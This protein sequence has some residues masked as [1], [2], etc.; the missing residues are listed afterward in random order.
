M[1]DEGSLILVSNDWTNIRKKR[2][3]ADD[4]FSLKKWSEALDEY[5]ELV[6][7]SLNAN[8]PEDLCYFYY[9]KGKC[10]YELGVSRFYFFRNLTTP[11]NN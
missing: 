4:L 6:I 8:K 10:L 2:K 7:Q 5:S 3:T 1:E 11:S 9:C